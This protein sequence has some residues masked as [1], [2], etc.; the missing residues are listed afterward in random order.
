M[1]KISAAIRLLPAIYYFYGILLYQT[2]IDSCQ[3]TKAALD[4]A[5]KAA[6]KDDMVIGDNI[7]NKVCGGWEGNECELLREEPRV[8]KAERINLVRKLKLM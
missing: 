2:N 8:Y 1:M 5:I 3:N 4:S 7:A 6:H